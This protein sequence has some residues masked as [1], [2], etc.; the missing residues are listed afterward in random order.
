MRPEPVL[1]GDDLYRSLLELSTEAIAR[2]EL[3][4]PMPI[5]LSPGE[6]IAH[7]LRHARIAECNEAYARLYDRSVAEMAGRTVAEVIPG[8]GAARGRLPLR[9]L[10][11]SP[12][13]RRTGPRRGRTGPRAG[14]Q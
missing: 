7:I 5:R 12:G 10:R 4:P 1:A 2:F 13:P 9:R 14:W 3:Q 11:L 6:Q 8:R